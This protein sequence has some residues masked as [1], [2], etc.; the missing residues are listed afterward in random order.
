MI[1]SFFPGRVRL[2]APIFKETE[3]VNKAKAILQSSSSVEKVENNPLTGSVLVEYDTEKVPMDKLIPMQ[4]FFMK[5]A[6]KAQNY[7]GE[8]KSEILSML[9]ELEALVKTW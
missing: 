2:R 8:N 4:D 5:L 1:T 3:L 9:D 7:S 6:K